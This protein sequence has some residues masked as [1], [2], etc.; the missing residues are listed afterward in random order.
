MRKYARTM[1]GVGLCL[2]LF[3]SW[4]V[5]TTSRT[6]AERQLELISQAMELIESGVYIRAVPLLEEAAELNA[7]HTAV[8]ENELKKV[9]LHLIENRG[10][11]RKYTNLLEKQMERKDAVP[12]VFIEAANFYIENSKLQ[13]GLAVLRNGIARTEAIELIELYENSRYEYRL[14]RNAYEEVTRIFNGTIQVRQ[15][16]EWGIAEP[17]G[18]III[19]CE[20]DKISNFYLD[21][22]IVR[23]GKTIYAVD[24]NN[25]RVALAQSDVQDFGNFADGRVSLLI[26]DKWQRATGD[27]EIGSYMFEEIGMYSNNFTAAKEN[28]WW[29]VIDRSTNWLLAPQ[30]DEIIQDEL[31]RCYAQNAVFARL[32]DSVYLYIDGVRLDAVFDDARP[33]EDEGYA[34]VKKNG[35][36][37]FIDS[38]GTLRIQYLF[39]EALSFG[40]HLAAVK[41]GDCWGYINVYGNVVIDTQFYSAKSF[42]DGSAPVLT[43]R[44]WQFITLIEYKRGITQ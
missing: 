3:T 22:A 14:N 23:N 12:D 2:L 42:S 25:N 18:T 7:T 40:Q 33:F 30:Y 11:S 37:G 10:F 1:V 31:G 24:R 13:E 34:T 17:I 41:H 44:G 26:N 27:F 4:I 38:S 5:V 9:Y 28:G 8:A 32:G 20:Y 39:D 21:T 15:N 35:K 19:P 29:G 6:T 43:D 36:W 16:G